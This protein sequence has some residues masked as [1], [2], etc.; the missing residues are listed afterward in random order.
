[1]ITAGHC[2]AQGAA[3][4]SPGGPS[5]GTAGSRAGYPATDMELLF[6][7]TYGSTIYT[8]NLTGT[9]T[10]VTPATGNPAGSPAQ[11]CHSGVFSAVVCAHVL[12]SQ[13]AQI[14]DIDGCTNNLWQ[15]SGGVQRGDSGS[16]FYATNGGNAQIRGMVVGGVFAPGAT[17]GTSILI[18]P[19]TQIAARYTGLLPN[20]G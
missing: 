14:C 20:G 1:M 4:F 2:F 8:G 17:V 5:F 9:A 13:T 7:S 12:Q 3:V 15:F 19:W 16:P 11:Y 18:H 10:F 6:G